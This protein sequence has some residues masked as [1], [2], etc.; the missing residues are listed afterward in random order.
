MLSLLLS[1]SSSIAIAVAVAIKAEAV[2]EVRGEK[3]GVLGVLINDYLYRTRYI[4]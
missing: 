1:A 2:E 3:G 4:V